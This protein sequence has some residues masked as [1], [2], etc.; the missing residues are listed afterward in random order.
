MMDGAHFFP[1]GNEM[2]H[3]HIHTLT[4]THTECFSNYQREH[5]LGSSVVW[6]H[7]HY[8]GKQKKRPQLL[9]VEQADPKTTAGGA[10][11]GWWGRGFVY[12][13]YT[14]D[15]HHVIITNLINGGAIM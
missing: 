10:V 2:T 3:T 5:S 9:P 7:F 14:N 11:G 6:G 4:D 15:C 13:S 8:H 12:R 1:P